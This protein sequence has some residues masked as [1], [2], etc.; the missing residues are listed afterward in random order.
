MIESDVVFWDGGFTFFTGT[1]GCSSGVY[2]EDVAT[3]EFGHMAGVGHSSVSNAT[4]YPYYSLCSSNS[5][6][7]ASDDQDGIEALYPEAGDSPPPTSPSD[8]SASPSEGTPTSAIELTWTDNADDEDGHAIERSEDGANYLEITE[9]G[10]DQTAYTESDLFADTTYWYRIRAF[11]VG[12][13]SEYSN[14]ASATTDAVDPKPGTPSNPN[15]SDGS[16][17]VKGS[18]RDPK[19]LRLTWSK[20]A[21]A[22]QYDVYFGTSESPPLYQSDVSRN[23]LKVNGLTLSPT[24]FWRIVAKNGNSETSGP[25]WQFTTGEASGPETPSSPRPSDGTSGVKKKVRLRW[26]KAAGA[27]QYDVYFGTSESQPLYQSDVSRNR[28]KVNGLASSQTY[29]WRIVAKNSEAE[30]SGSTWQFTTKD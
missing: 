4:M 27:Q 2:I 10:A 11:G 13:Y 19:S 16:T 17:G 14:S 9:V 25:T 26:S 20:A 12:G 21:G 29:F 6:T 18:K 1:S 28:L 23:R 7:L 8:L 22:K 15:P 30:T 24:Y 3:H 5:R